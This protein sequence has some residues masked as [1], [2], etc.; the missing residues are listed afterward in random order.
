LFLSN[1][2]ATGNFSEEEGVAVVAEREVGTVKWFNA[3]KGYGFIERES[4]GDIFVHFSEI[5]AEGYRK[6]M[7]GQKV[8]FSVIET[9]KGQQ[10]H[11]V[12]LVTE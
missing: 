4:G 1:K 7:Q 3:A 2:V 12:T 8:E 9:E 5:T 6:L 10:A 11:E